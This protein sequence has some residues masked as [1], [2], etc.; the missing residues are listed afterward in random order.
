MK[1]T[2]KSFRWPVLAMVLAATTA[3]CDDF[4]DVN[5][6]PNAP[7]KVRPDLRLAG[8]I[9]PFGHSLYYGDTQ[10]WGSEW[11]QQFSYNGETRNY[12]EIHRYELQE[13]DASHAWDFYFA[14]VLNDAKMIIDETDPEVDGPM[15]GIAKFL[16]AWGYAHVTDM[17]GP[18][19]FTEAFN[20][21][22]REPKYDDQQTVYAAVH[23]LLEEAIADMQRPS[24]RDLTNID[25]L[26]AGDMA[27]WVKLARHV[28]ARHHLAARVRAGRE[29]TAARAGD[30]YRASGWTAEQC[31]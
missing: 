13:S 14:G 28:Q 20:T 19:P 2:L 5:D 6:N 23:Q 7:E 18:V 31:R 8:I 3:A 25:L 24:T 22:I 17:W 4:L 21:R 1:S 15:H 10:L 26:F 29:P 30:A 16:F 27:R 11:M 12:A 9:G